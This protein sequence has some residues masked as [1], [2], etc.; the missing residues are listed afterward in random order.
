[1]GNLH[2]MNTVFP[3]VNEIYGI[4]I[5]LDNFEDIALTGWETIGNKHTRLYKYTADTNDKELVL[6]CN[7]DIIEA[8]Y[9][10]IIDA[11]VSSNKTDFLDTDAINTENYIERS[12]KGVS[13]FYVKGKLIKYKEGDGV[14]YFERDFRNVT[15]LYHGI[16]VEDETGLPLIN[17]KEERAIAAFVAWRETYK[18]GLKKKDRNILQF[19]KDLE[20]EWLRKCNAARIPEKLNQND[21]NNI[22]DVKA[23]WDRKLFNKTYNPIK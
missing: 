5:K 16:L 20:A 23:C 11:Q 10:P 4:D 7:A 9:I 18:E 22:L 3:L 17:N 1:M 2:S 13:P 14:L 21:M 15:V 19:A 8:V 12:K 6:P